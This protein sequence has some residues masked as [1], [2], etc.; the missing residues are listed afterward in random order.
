MHSAAAKWLADSLLELTSSWAS[1]PNKVPAEIKALLTQ[2]D[3][4]IPELWTFSLS[5]A[6]LYH[7]EADLL[8]P[9]PS[10]VSSSG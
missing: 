7:R 2:N 6:S 9:P 1:V 3:F 5:V 10:G 8:L 4:K